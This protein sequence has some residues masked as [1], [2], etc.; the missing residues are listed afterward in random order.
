MRQLG[1]FV[2]ILFLM[3]SMRFL[4]F[5][6]GRPKIHDGQV[7]SFET[8]LL[9][10]PN[11]T[12]RYQQFPVNLS[13]TRLLVYAPIYPKFRYGDRLTI[14]GKVKE[15]KIGKATIFSMSYPKI[16]Q[17]EESIL[18]P[19]AFIRQRIISLFETALPGDLASLLLGIV[20]GIKTS[21][22][23]DFA[24]SLRQS[25]VT[26][27][28]AASG[29]NVAMVAGFL[30]TLFGLFF[31]RQR[32]LIFSI[33]GICFYAVVAGLQAS[34]VRASIMGTLVFLSQILGLQ[35]LSWYLLL[36]AG[37]VMLMIDPSLLFDA[38][39]QL[40]FAATAGLLFIQPLMKFGKL[41]KVIGEDVKTTISAQIATVPILLGNFGSYSLFSILANALVLWMISILM[42]LGGMGA[43][44]GLVIPPVGTLFL[45]L[46]LPF[47]YLFQWIISLFSFLPTISVF[48]IPA[49]FLGYYMVLISLVIYIKSKQK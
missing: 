5:Y 8:A 32:A 10:D 34:I 21:M 16:S 41:E 9:A 47:L 27:V 13:G 22:S 33:L 14:A 7:L 20:F 18:V 2:V 11:V 36:L 30:S 15:K 31:K 48:P 39:F 24:L 17:E 19:I 45:W 29:M 3:L 46:A 28:V 12:G 26:H 38:G 44:V 6:Q 40:S 49:M 37:F 42:I 4:F 35:V 25:G 43:I 23:K 1:I